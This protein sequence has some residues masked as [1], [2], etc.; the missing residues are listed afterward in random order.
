VGRSTYLLNA[1]LNTLR[2]V[3]F[4]VSTVYAS[5]HTGNPGITG[6]NEATGG[7]YAR[8]AVTLGAPSGGSES[9]SVAL[10]FTGMPA[11]GAPG[12][13]HI[14]VWDAVSAGN[15]LWAGPMG[16]RDIRAFTAAASTDILTVPGSAYSASTDMADLV[17]IF[18][19]ALPSG[20]SA[21]TN[22]FI[23]TV[24]GVTTKLSLTS[25]GSAID[26]TAD[27]GGMIRRIQ[28]KTVN[29][30]DTVNVAI[31]ALTLTQI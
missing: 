1:E 29:S 5:L 3:S 21:L 26:L 13:T 2:A 25:G 15:F 8:Q 19:Q 12:I 7:S 4:S 27:G 6:A 11:V 10:N 31:G 18:D 9:T 22:Y 17:T 30:G 14:A 20:V 24:S 23:V 16:T 28:A